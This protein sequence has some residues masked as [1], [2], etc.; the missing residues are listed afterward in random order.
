MII[1]KSGKTTGS[2]LS[3]SKQYIMFK[4]NDNNNN[5][6]NTYYKYQQQNTTTIKYRMVLEVQGILHPSQDIVGDHSGLFSDGGV[7]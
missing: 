7:E 2:S 3:F 6:C 1:I 5:N 4:T